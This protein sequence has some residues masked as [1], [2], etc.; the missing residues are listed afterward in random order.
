ML[1]VF[2]CSCLLLLGVPLNAPIS[3]ANFQLFR[4][5]TLPKTLANRRLQANVNTFDFL[6]PVEFQCTLLIYVYISC[7]RVLI[8]NVAAT[9]LLFYYDSYHYHQHNFLY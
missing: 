2:S 8:F 4:E 7:L 9:C 5:P 6:D 1:T 3:M